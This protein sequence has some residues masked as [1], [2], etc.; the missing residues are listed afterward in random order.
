MNERAQLNSGAWLLWLCINQWHRIVPRRHS[1]ELL[2]SFSTV[3]QHF[4][5]RMPVE[6]AQECEGDE[7]DVP[8]NEDEDEGARAMEALQMED[9]DDEVVATVA[10]V[11]AKKKK[12]KKKKAKKME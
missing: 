5:E 12:K 10:P 6:L 1:H 8:A 11:P 2:D 3:R 4:K 9:E 7:N